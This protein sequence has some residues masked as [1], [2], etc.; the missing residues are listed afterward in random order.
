MSFIKKLFG[1]YETKELKKIEP[2]KNSVLALES[3]YAAMS[4]AQLRRQTQLL[5]DRL[6]AGETLEDIMADAYAVCREGASRVL[7]MKHY[8]VQIVGGIV[9][10][11]GNIAEMKTGEGKTLVATLPVYLNALTGKG[12]HVVTVNDYLAERD[13]MWMGKLYEFLGLTVG[14]IMPGMEAKEK[15]EAYNCDITYGTNSEFGFDYLRDN[16]VVYKESQVQRPFYF[17]LVDE[18]DSILIDEARTPLIISGQGEKSSDNYRLA[19]RFAKSLSYYVIAE[20]DSK[21]DLD[22]IEQDVIV[23]EKARQATLT[24]HGIEKAEKYFNIENYSDPENMSLTHY[25]TQALQANAIMKKDID[26]VIKDRQI[27][28]VDEFTGRLM[29]GRRYGNGLHQAIEAKEGTS[30]QNENKT[31]A[32]ITYQNYFR[33]YPKLAGMTGTAMTE[34]EEFLEIYGLSVVEVPTNKDVKRIDHNDV[35]YKTEKAKFNAVIDEAIAAHEKGQP[36]LIGTVTVEKS[37]VLYDMLKKRGIRNANLLNADRAKQDSESKI[38]AQAGRRGAITIATNMAGRGTDIKLG[39]NLEY[40]LKAMLTNNQVKQFLNWDKLDKAT[41]EAVDRLKSNYSRAR[42]ERATSFIDIEELGKTEDIKKQLYEIREKYNAATEL[43]KPV[44]DQEAQ[45]VKEAGGLLIL[46]TER[47]ESRRIDNQL[48]GRS[49]RQGDPGE[50]RFYV[51]LEDDLMR[52]FGGEKTTRIMEKL[53]YDETMPIENKMINSTIESA[54]KRIEGRNF[55]IRKNV[56]KYDEVLNSQ[57]DIIYK[58]RSEVLNDG[59]VSETVR[60]MLTQTITD[61]VNSFCTEEDPAEW[62]LTSLKNTFIG[63]RLLNEND[64]NWTDAER[65]TLTADGLTENLI[66]RAINLLKVKEEL[67]G[68]DVMRELERIVLL[69]A[70][71]NKWTDHMDAMEELRRG[72]GLRSYGQHDPFTVYRTEGFAMFDEMIEDI[73]NETAKMLVLRPIPVNPENLKRQQ[74]TVITGTNDASRRAR[75]KQPAKVQKIGRNDPCPCGSGKKY[76]QCHG[77]P[78]AGPLPQ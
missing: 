31:V 26:Y 41:K 3:K 76:K 64:W 35:V 71:D 7:H 11:R 16:M 75:K 17:A 49:G 23:D 22:T 74:T 34:S 56:L 13:S 66:T 20:H 65:A 5:R 24:K 73:R 38:I 61:T 44:Y 68:A 42:L 2:I 15:R 55:D 21:E 19:D 12:V 4:N 48:R 70:V 69:K 77:R 43:L 30:V 1:S 60:N 40:D 57:R 28:I 62:N 25:I 63:W 37:Q 58:Q 59:D 39:G 47:H 8:P 10:H 45:L 32:S 78:G 27:V 9:L 53:G 29:E 50:S 33:L 46:G 36:V 54:Q 6:A 51:S 14:L 67:A 52:L 18:V 72:M